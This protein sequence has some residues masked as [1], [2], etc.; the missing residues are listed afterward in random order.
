[1]ESD[2]VIRTLARETLSSPELQARLGV[3]QPTAS[4]L[5]RAAGARVVRLGRGPATRYAA[6]RPVFAN[7]LALPLFTVDGAGVLSE[8]AELR[9]LADGRYLV[10]PARPSSARS[11]RSG[12][13][14]PF[15]L[16]GESGQGL[17]DSLPYFLHDL[18]P[19][20][21]LGR[22]LARRLAPEWDTPSD[23]RDWSDDP[24]GRYLV[25]LGDDLPG[26]LVVGE[27]AAAR[28]RRGAVAPEVRLAD[29]PR[30]AERA[31]DGDAPGSS[32]AGEQPKLAVRR[33]RVGPVIVKFSPAARNA[34]G[35][36][37]RDLLRSEQH[38][39]SLLRARGIPAAES[40][41]HVLGGRVF[42]E[43]RRFDRRGD[44]G[45]V[46]AIS[47]AMIDAE[48][49]GA[50]QGWTRVARVLAERGLLDRGSRDRIE[51][52]EL[53]GDWIGNTDMHLG[54]VSLEPRERG[55]RLHPIYDML[56][57]GLAPVRGELPTPPPLRPPVR[58]AGGE[59]A[60]RDAG[61]TARVYWQRI[62][63]DR[64]LSR[65]FR[66]LARERARAIEQ[67]LVG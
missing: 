62:A 48:L 4:R 50:G 54:N 13:R 60:W 44:E 58:P 35:T 12:A 33:A 24:I 21:F 56:P 59:R 16:L 52:L 36:R 22:Q 42:L 7:G 47:L 27:A 41:L 53:F 40:S 5:L 14:L 38:A 20:G 26:N 61:E 34:E 39:L 64:E 19:S 29:Y 49:V 57:M 45:R 10:E 11:V 43:T 55:F 66:A 37:W 2:D 1:M 8:L 30:L 63:D 3:S 67:A 25:E 65:G 28:I 6:A 46:A 32:A 23:P 31:L 15:W 51:W 9:A 18:R 17:F